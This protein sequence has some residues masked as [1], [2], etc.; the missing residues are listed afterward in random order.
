MNKIPAIILAIVRWITKTEH[1]YKNANEFD[2]P[3][4]VLDYEE[5]LRKR[6]IG[7]EN[8][9]NH[10]KYWIVGENNKW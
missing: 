2:I 5:Q 6:Q 8:K 4:T 10:I 9:I 3:D 7:L 1:P